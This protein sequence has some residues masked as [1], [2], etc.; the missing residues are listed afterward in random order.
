MY[1]Y[2]DQHYNHTRVLH[3]YWEFTFL[4]RY[5]KCFVLAC[6]LLDSD[7]IN[8][9]ICNHFCFKT[10]HNVSIV[11]RGFISNT[12]GNVVLQLTR[13]ETAWLSPRALYKMARVPEK[14]AA[15]PEMAVSFS[16]FIQHSTPQCFSQL[17]TFSFHFNVLLKPVSFFC[18][19]LVKFINRT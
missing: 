16:T 17:N 2:V 12:L 9:R 19:P 7:G 14:G 18:V 1:H 5:R 6:H 4:K 8:R 11:Y 10:Y 3:V 15:S 13:V